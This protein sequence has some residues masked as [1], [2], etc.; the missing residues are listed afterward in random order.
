MIFQETVQAQS[1]SYIYMVLK[2]TGDKTRGGNKNLILRILFLFPLS[3]E[4][5]SII[6][7]LINIK[8]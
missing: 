3:P 6:L 2:T 8:M 4:V 7:T 1:E 5:D